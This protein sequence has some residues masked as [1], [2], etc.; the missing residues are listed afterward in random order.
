MNSIKAY[1]LSLI[2][3]LLI[4]V[5]LS[6][7]LFINIKLPEWLG[8]IIFLTVYS[9]VIGVVPY[10]LLTFLLLRV[11]KNKEESNIKRILLLSPI[12]LLPILLVFIQIVGFLR[13]GIKSLSEFRS[14]L[15]N[16]LINFADG[17]T[18]RT[19]RRT[20]GVN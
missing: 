14:H 9:G 16:S 17:T 12:I 5:L 15:K 10:I 8:T 20:M 7:L 3:P 19:N 13:F 2:L 6:P 18:R 1:K 11:M 4:P